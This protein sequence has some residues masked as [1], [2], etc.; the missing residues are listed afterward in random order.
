[1]K[2]FIILM[3]LCIVAV[4]AFAD[5]SLGVNIRGAQGSVAD[6]GVEAGISF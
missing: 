5:T 4:S 6:I 1:M 3:V 2:R